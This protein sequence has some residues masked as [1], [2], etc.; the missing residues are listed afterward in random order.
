MTPLMKL[1]PPLV[2]V[3]L[4]ALAYLIAFAL[5]FD[6]VRHIPVQHVQQFW[7]FLAVLPL[8]RLGCNAAWGLYRHVWRYVGMRD[9]LAILMA[10]LV[11]SG[12]F[13]LLA[14]MTGQQGF[15][16]TV[17]G[18]EFLLSL[19]FFT[20]VR[21]GWRSWAERSRGGVEGA[22]R[23]LIVGA[24]D[25]GEMLVRDMMRHPERGLLPVGFVDDDK[26]RR[27]RRIH[28][29]EVLGGRDDLKRLVAERNADLVVLAMPSAGL[30]EVRAI[31]KLAADTPALVKT[32]PSLHDIIGGNVSV[33][34]MRD[35]AIEDLLGRDPAVIDNSLLG[36]LKGARVLV[37][38]AGGSIGAELCRQ[39]AAKQPKELICLGHGE[40]SIYLI[41]Q[42]LRAS[43]SSLVPIIA[44]VR[45]ESRID[46]VF[47]RYRPEV[48]FHAAAHKHVPLMEAN[49]TEAAANN[50]IGTRVVAEA[51]DRHGAARFV[52]VSTDK[53]V[54]PTS[55]MGK[56]KRTAELQVQDL[57]SRSNTL[58]LAVRFGNVLGSRGSV[59]PLF[60]KQIEAGGPV[61]VTH[62][63][64]RRYFMTIPEAVT[65]VLQAAN[66]GRQGEILMLDMGDPV[67]I[68]DLARNLIKLSGFKIDDVGIQFSGMRPGEKL[69]EEL[70]LTDE[71]ARPTEHPQIFAVKASQAPDSDWWR[72]V[73]ARLHDALAQQ[74]AQG[75]R[76]ILDE[77]VARDRKQPS[78]NGEET[79][80]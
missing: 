19:F 62:P 27:G 40:N 55:V 50:V 1:V 18:I 10:T 64:M 39:I 25:A 70:L 33:S 21:I 74:S 79:T 37:T 73:L 44:S 31:L 23:T 28:G 32:L 30:K 2:D 57:S 59:V 17:V 6:S 4:V 48:V 16:R 75:V 43:F 46:E 49:E 80:H 41:E 42:E 38:G 72:S 60:R 63:D 13:A 68:V 12:I 51:A 22:S 78:P 20:G 52:L 14:L 8:I 54:N 29:V 3:I 35:V 66:L 71:V 76:A 7:V 36:Y 65:L 34:Q 67:R 58:F 26:A 47:A 15:P 9:A 5:R 11:G 45:D 53:A 24:G 77:V 56:T 69:F 61:T